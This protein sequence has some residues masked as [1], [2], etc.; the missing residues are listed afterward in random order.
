MSSISTC[1]ACRQLPVEREVLLETEKDFGAYQLCFGCAMRLE[2][3]SLRPVEWFNLA[4]IHSPQRYH[5]HDDFYDED[6]KAYQPGE[7]VDDTPA[8]SIPLVSD[9]LGNQERLVDMVMSRWFYSHYYTPE[10]ASAVDQLD[11]GGLLEC[12]KRRVA[13]SRNPVIVSS[14]YRIAEVNLKNA[15]ADWIRA[16]ESK[17]HPHCFLAW[18]CAC[19]T[20]L[21]FEE[22]FERVTSILV[23]Q[24]R[25][26]DRLLTAL[27]SFHGDRVLDWIEG[28]IGQPITETWG[29]A[30]ALAGFSWQRAEKWLAGGRPLSLVA[31]D[32]LN[33]CW[34]YNTGR[35]KEAKPKLINPASRDEIISTLRD[36]AAK[37]A[38]PRPER[39]VQKVIDH[40]DVIVN[41]LG[42]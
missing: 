35:L 15:A 14:A 38:W 19:G 6:G 10:L 7:Y 23:R 37:D 3:F 13:A 36:Y 9:I 4:A 41:N 17:H 27:S 33:A 39:A 28:N 5:L 29:Q 18:A 12:I 42:K 2:R 31:L 22:G 34:N 40:L 11:H 30:A 32:A 1:Q 16:Q 8:S 20:C 26:P 25:N 24:P 21:P